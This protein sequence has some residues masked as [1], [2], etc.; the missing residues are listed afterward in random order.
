MALGMI[1]TI[2]GIALAALSRA[3]VSCICSSEPSWRHRADCAGVGGSVMVLVFG[4][5]YLGSSPGRAIA[6]MLRP[7]GK[8]PRVYF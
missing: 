2:G 8:W 3:A 6:N 5:W 1:T 4:G 7:S